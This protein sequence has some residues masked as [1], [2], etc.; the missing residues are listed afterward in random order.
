MRERDVRAKVDALI[1]ALPK[2][3]RQSST[4]DAVCQEGVVFC[5]AAYAC[6]ESSRDVRCRVWVVAQELRF[7]RALG[8]NRRRRTSIAV[9][10]ARRHEN[11]QPS[12]VV[13]AGTRD[14]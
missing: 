13:P 3:K 1:L 2:D 5:H 12:A 11:K 4:A 6:T 7:A 10:V 9:I 14:V 8:E